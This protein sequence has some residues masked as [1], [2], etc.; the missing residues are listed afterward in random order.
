M[1]P[2]R[3]FLVMAAASASVVLASPTATPS[4][5]PDASP[6]RRGLVNTGAQAFNGRKTFDGGIVLGATNTLAQ[7]DVPPTV[8]GA[9]FTDPVVWLKTNGGG[10]SQ[11]HLIQFG[12]GLTSTTW[13]LALGWY[14]PALVP[15]ISS[16]S[17]LLVLTVMGGALSPF[18]P[19]GTDLG[20]TTNTWRRLHL[21]DRVFQSGTDSS[22]TPGAATINKPSGRSAIA[23][24]AA[25]VVI[26]NNL[27]TAN[28]LVSIT[29]E[30]DHG[31][32]RDWVTRS[33]GVSFTVNLNAAAAANTAFSWTVQE[34]F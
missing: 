25:S 10:T 6:T 9:S 3:I 23:S 24:G 1:S 14:G 19:S 29:W 32:T 31:Q 16:R 7:F 20:T 2:A 18:T 26:T 5:P 17:S 8:A 22:G 34:F 33:A 15:V 27:V 4:A 11:L 13:E 21:S 28:S 12:S 30:G